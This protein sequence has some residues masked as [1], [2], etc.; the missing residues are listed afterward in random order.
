MARIFFKFLSTRVPKIYTSN[1][2]TY[3]SLCVLLVKEVR[4]EPCIT[5]FKIAVG[6]LRLHTRTDNRMYK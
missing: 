5:S 1:L 2:T 6:I 4:I 3:I